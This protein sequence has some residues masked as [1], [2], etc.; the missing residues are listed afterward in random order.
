[1]STLN[2]EFKSLIG[3][4]FLGNGFIEYKRGWLKGKTFTCPYCG[5]ENKFGVNPSSNFYH[6]FRCDSKGSLIDLIIELEKLDSFYEVKPKLEKWKQ[7]GWKVK[8]ETFDKPYQEVKPLILPEGF[9]LLTHGDSVI[10]RGVRNKLSKRGLDYKKLSYKGWGYCDKG[11]YMG[12]LI[13]PYHK[14]GE[15]I[16][17]NAR[18]MVSIGPRYLNP[19]IGD[20][21][22][23]SSIGKSMIIY[24]EDALYMYNSVFLCEGA[25]N[26][27]T[28]SPHRGICSGGKYVS[29]YQINKIIKS[30]VK[31]VIICMD[32]DAIKQSFD[33]CMKLIENKLIKV[34]VFPEGKDAND[35]GRSESLKLVYKTKYLHSINEALNL[36][37][38]YET[39]PIITH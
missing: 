20:D 5:R 2:K 25:I 3:N 23:N 33:V 32:S 17:F 24:N 39:G 11:K 18:N 15:L 9:K 34:V 27:E 37:R 7:L 29:S 35:L 10:A 6:C 16:Y 30:P 38:I 28:L 19:D 22:G 1:M 4:Y 21:Q 12:Y 14:D 36:K 8:I 31:R 13:I 26:A